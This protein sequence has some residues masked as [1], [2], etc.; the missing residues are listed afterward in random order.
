MIRFRSQTLLIYDSETQTESPLDQDVLQHV[1]EHAFAQSGIHDPTIPTAVLDSVLLHYQQSV[2]QPPRV[3]RDELVSQLTRVL[4]E[5]GH[6]EAARHVTFLATV[7]PPASTKQPVTSFPQEHS[8]ELESLP[9][10]LRP[11]RYL[12][13]QEWELPLMQE[14]QLLLQKQ[15]VTLLPIS[16]A[17]PV[18]A[19]ECRPSRLYDLPLS[20]QTELELH[21]M[22]AS[23]VRQLGEILRLMRERVNALWGISA[24]H[25]A[26]VHFLEIN[27]LVQLSCPSRNA[28][29]R[30]RYNRLLR[31]ELTS[32]LREANTFQL[33]IDFTD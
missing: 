21:A 25:A 11:T 15:V 4:Q 16:D 1:L 12:G 27:A 13:A 18:V 32:P 9:P 17:H 29:V 22:L 7:F 24:E 10:V 26:H 6:P 8:A 30:Q 20:P 23:L 5:L 19:V 2:P 33:L 28:K 31:E 3:T 14:S